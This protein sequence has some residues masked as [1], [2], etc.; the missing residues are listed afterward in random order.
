MYEIYHTFANPYRGIAIATAA[1]QLC[2]AIAGKK[3]A[4][5]SYRGIARANNIISTFAF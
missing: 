2:R 3:E 4:A 5:H 1:E